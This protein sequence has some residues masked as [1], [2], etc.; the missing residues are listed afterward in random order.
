MQEITLTLTIEETNAI[1][2]VLGELPSKTG[3][4]PLIIKIKDQV[5]SQAQTQED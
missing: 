5:D 2:N 3:A 4:W 1:L